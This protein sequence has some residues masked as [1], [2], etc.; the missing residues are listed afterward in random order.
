MV[1]TTITISNSDIT[2]FTT[3]CITVVAGHNCSTFCPKY[4]PAG[5]TGC[6]SCCKC[7]CG[8][9]DIGPCVVNDCKFIYSIYILIV[10]V[11]LSSLLQIKLR[12]SFFALIN[13]KT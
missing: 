12:K 3:S 8:A 13:V 10:I 6:V 2:A 9:A 11:F 5:A 1:L 4:A 7:C